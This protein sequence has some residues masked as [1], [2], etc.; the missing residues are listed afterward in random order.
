MGGAQLASGFPPG[1]AQAAIQQEINLL[2]A[3]GDRTL[4]FFR[5]KLL[6]HQWLLLR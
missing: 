1:V 3:K 4:G 5:H 2:R 6:L